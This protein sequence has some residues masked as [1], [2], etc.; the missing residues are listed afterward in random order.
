MHVLVQLQE[1]RL[2]V[3][4]VAVVRSAE[5]RADVVVVLQLVALVHQLMGPRYHP[6]VVRV[7]EL[8]CDI[9][10][11]PLLTAPKRKPAPRGLEPKPVTVSSG[12]LHNK[13]EPAPF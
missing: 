5:D 12:S 6:Q 9:L 8:L 10:S 13:S 2:V 11:S 7:I 3:A 4:P 1:G